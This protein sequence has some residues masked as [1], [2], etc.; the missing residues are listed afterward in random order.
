MSGDVAR[1]SGPKGSREKSIFNHFLRVATV[2]RNESVLGEDSISYKVNLRRLGVF[3][4]WSSGWP[5]PA[6]DSSLFNLA[7]EHTFKDPGKI[8]GEPEVVIHRL[9][10]TLTS[11]NVQSLER[12]RADLLRD[13]KEKDL[14][15][16][17]PVRMPTKTLRIT[18]RKTLRGEGS[19]TWDCF[20][21]RSCRRLIDLHSPSEIVLQITSFGLE[22][23]VEVE[24]TSA[25]A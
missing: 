4:E 25:D 23:G 22:P 21:V 6:P 24:V 18:T 13:A 1:H 5:P 3:V 2:N 19:K 12:V 17:G 8:P 16:K 7:E 20:Q 15:V 10:I 11:C 9:R 14:V